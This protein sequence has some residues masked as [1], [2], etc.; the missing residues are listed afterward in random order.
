MD[1]VHHEDNEDI[2]ITPIYIEHGH[3]GGVLLTPQ[4]I[5]RKK[6][7][8]SEERYHRLI[9]SSPSAIGILSGEDL[10]ITIGNDPIFEIWGKGRSI[11]GMP[12]FEALPELAEQGYR[13]VFGEVYRTGI[14]FNA[15]ETPVHIEQNGEMTLKYYNF[16]LYPQRD[17]DG[18]VNGIGIIATEVTSQA[19]LNNKIKKSEQSIRALVESA[20]FPIAVYTGKEMRIEF[21]NQSIIDVWGKGDDVVGQL[22]TDILPELEG[23]AIF[24]QVQQVYSTGIAFH[25][26]NQR[27]DLEIDGVLKPY[28]FNYSFTPLFDADGQV[29]GVMN[30]AAEITELN[31]AKRK[32]EESEKRFKDSVM[33]APL[34]IAI[35]SGPDFVTE[36]A[37]ENYLLLV[38][39]TEKELIGKPLFQV[40]PEVKRLVAPL[41]AGV[42]KTGKQ[43]HSPELP[44]TLKRHGQMQHCYFNL[45]Y[46]PLKEETGEIKSI[47]VV[48]TEVTETVKAKHLLEESEKHFRNMVMQSPIPMTILRGENFIIDSGNKVMFETIWNKK[49]EDIV[50]KSLLDVFPELKGQKYPEL[51]KGVYHTGISHTEKESV[52]LIQGD[53]GLHKFYL[54][55]EYAP[56]YDTDGV[57]TGIMITI[58]DVTDKVE[59]RQKV[60]EAEE[61]SRLAAEAT[62][63]ATWELDLETR[64]LY[65]TPRLAEIY[66]HR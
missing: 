7:E 43:F 62:D 36:L 12:Y 61:R 30:T 60:E 29:Y 47:M 51:L 6:V 42:I 28:Y 9:H 8:E 40:V 41:F 35:F 25:A 33:Q 34:G 24:E 22:Y 2:N 17:A 57:V 63:L 44:A 20:P 18:A 65:H 11:T 59:A 46:H 50:G 39:K 14:P 66:G 45:V 56:L 5:A 23:Q 1:E 53:D 37:N 4:V 13:E 19:L 38:D 54:D 27:V 49:Q 10:V 26:K 21:A 31:E 64:I 55:F 3:I 48:A 58:N 52:A 15:V 16:L 32:V